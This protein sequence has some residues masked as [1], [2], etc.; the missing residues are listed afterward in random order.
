MT[1]ILLAVENL[2]K[3]NDKYI[4]EDNQLLK[5]KVYE[6]VMNTDKALLSLLL[7]NPTVKASF[8]EEV[9]DILIFD[10]QKFTWFIESKAFLPNSY[11]RY[12]NKIGLT[13]DSQFISHTNDVVLDFPYK[14]CVLAGG[15]DKDN[16][17][18][19]EVFYHETI[20]NE[21]I[22]RMLAPKVLTNAKRY[23]QAGVEEGITFTDTDN[24]IIKG[25]NLIA[26]ASLL[27]RYEGKVKCIY[28]D[29]PYNTGK[30]SFKYNDSFNHSTW[31][32]FMKNRLELAKKLLKEDG[33]IFV[34]LDDSESHYCKVLMDSIFGSECF[35]REIVWLKGNA[36]NDSKGIQKN[37]ESILVY[38]KNINVGIYNE[39][40]YTEVEIFKEGNR[41]FYKGSGIT[42]GGEGGTLNAR[43]NLGATIYYHPETKAINVVQDYDIEKAKIENEENIVY[44]DSQDLLDKGFVKIRAP[45][46]GEKLGCWTWSF[47][48]L[49]EEKNHLI[50]SDN[51]G[52][53]SVAKKEYLDEIDVSQ[54]VTKKGKMLYCKK[55]ENPM[56][57]V[58]NI[59]SA[60]GTKELKAL[61]GKKVFDNPKNETLLQ[62]LF[63][64][65]TKQG[66][67]VLDF[68]LGSGTTSAVA[69]KMRRQYIG[70]E[71]MDYVE[72]ITVER[73]KKVIGGEQG[74]I[75]KAVDWNGGGSFV[76]C[77]LLENANELIESIKQS[78]E[79]DIGKIKEKIYDDERI[80]PYIQPAELESLDTDF[81]ALTLNEKKKILCQLIDKNKLYVNVSDMTDEDYQV[82]DTDRRFTDSFYQLLGK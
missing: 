45:Q 63:N 9:D 24:L 76:Y 20:A 79:K 46:K 36:Q 58:I 6:D 33:V 19:E 78:N 40:S 60:S 61:F 53:Y 17:K 27:K 11:T 50:I 65:S 2:L 64:I 67:I 38:T 10:K 39:A 4:S 41:Y 13:K 47:Q 14:D 80:L 68:F 32:T 29:P 30:D 62:K 70:I 1:N 49:S 16:E 69:H 75:S 3:T 28:I 73:M 8:F 81:N 57:N 21:H 12:T 55:T 56:K 74:G 35:V 5:T 25:N 18:R 59:S 34:S 82:S 22:S 37:T 52:K 42:T 23:T 51:R 26:L 44:T 54:I 48:K 72:E 7:S 71:Q 66:D 43:P 77:E 15:Q 31:L